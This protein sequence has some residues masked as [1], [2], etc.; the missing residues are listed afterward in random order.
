MFSCVDL[1][2]RNPRCVYT[3]KRNPGSPLVISK[4]VLEQI[5]SQKKKK[6]H[7]HTHKHIAPLIM[8]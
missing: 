6:K 4:P 7:T 2:L 3:C 1:S 8:Y 5:T